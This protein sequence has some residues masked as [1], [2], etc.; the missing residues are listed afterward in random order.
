MDLVNFRLET[1][2]DGIALVT[3]DAPA[4]SMNVIDQ[5]VITE[6]SHIVERVAADGAIKGAIIT[7]GKDAFCAG[8]D[9][10]MLE[11]FGR[12]AP[13][14]S[15][16]RAGA[17]GGDDQRAEDPDIARLFDDS[18]RLSLVYRRI[19]TCGKP[20]VAAIPG[21]ALGGGFELCLACHHRVAARNPRARV[22]LPEIKVG[23]FRAP[24]GHSAS[25]ACCR[26][27]TRCASCSR[28]IRS[29]WSRPRA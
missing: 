26:R 25:P 2:P 16:E 18:R 13:A 1:D 8:A 24:A 27:P 20:W 15:P 4:R 12:R 21:T 3:W 29:G 23:C 5:A 11:A 22:G 19:E 7:S 6:L 9:L 17:G 10:A 14:G 28:P